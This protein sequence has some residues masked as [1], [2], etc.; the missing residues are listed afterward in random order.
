M[1]VSGMQ[2]ES[3]RS[4][5][6][7]V[8]PLVLLWSGGCSPL[9]VHVTQNAELHSLSRLILVNDR[10]DELQL[11]VTVASDGD[12]LTQGRIR[13]RCSVLPHSWTRLDLPPGTYSLTVQESN[14]SVGATQ[15]Q[16][17]LEAGNNYFVFLR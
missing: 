16:L 10:V 7:T 2:L 3:V 5:A 1:Q 12:A 14:Q 4:T 9:S 11:N 15:L 8:L 17:M 13:F 6:R